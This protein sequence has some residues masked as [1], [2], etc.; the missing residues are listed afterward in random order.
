MFKKNRK[1]EVKIS[2]IK[3]KD[4]SI[5]LNDRF[6]LKNINCQINDKSITAILGPNGAGK[7]LLLQTING[8]IPILNGKDNL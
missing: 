7:S 5:S 1:S 6:I 4:L 3:I 8:L 2:P